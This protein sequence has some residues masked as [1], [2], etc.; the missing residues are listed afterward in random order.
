MES[1][2]DAMGMMGG[3]DDMIQMEIAPD[4]MMK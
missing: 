1:L 3:A 4:G 2:M